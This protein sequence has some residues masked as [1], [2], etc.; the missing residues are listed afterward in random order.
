MN[1]CVY[2][3]TFVR[4]ILY[5]LKLASEQHC[6]IFIFKVRPKKILKV[7]RYLRLSLSGV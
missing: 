3:H 5:Y 4:T 7:G 1:M 6:I 2:H